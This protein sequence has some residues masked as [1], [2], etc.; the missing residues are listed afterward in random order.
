MTGTGKAMGLV[1]LEGVD[2]AGTVKGD[3]VG[4]TCMDGAG[5]LLR[6]EGPEGVKVLVW[7]R[8]MGWWGW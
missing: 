5:K 7:K 4:G 8:L 6:L 3:E 2:V 1:E